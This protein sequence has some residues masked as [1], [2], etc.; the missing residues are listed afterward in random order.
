MS[1]TRDGGSVINIGRLGGA[2]A[3][4]DLDVLSYRHLTVGGVSF[5]FTPPEQI[6]EVV[7]A[8]ADGVIPAVAD[9][10]IRP[11]I[12]AVLSFDQAND[13]IARVRSGH[14]EGKV[15]LTVS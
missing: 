3:V 13:A 7:A 11:V 2:A 1:G 5:G 15:V 9:G 10:R 12:D 8:L 14:A 4:I 6:G